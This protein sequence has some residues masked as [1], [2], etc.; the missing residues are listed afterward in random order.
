[1][2]L[3]IGRLGT[4]ECERESA[5]QLELQPPRLPFDNLDRISN[6][7]AELGRETER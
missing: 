3:S 1:V 5:R 4:E 7:I 2:N 6:A